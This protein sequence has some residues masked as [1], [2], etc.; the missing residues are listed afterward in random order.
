[1]KDLLRN[2]FEQ[3][4][5]TNGPTRVVI[6]AGVLLAVLVAGVA[7]FQA[8]NPHFVMLY[9]DINDGDVAAVEAAIAKA[10]IR[11]RTSP[12]PGPYNIFVEESEEFAARAIVATESALLRDPGGIDASTGGASSVF[13]S[14]SERNQQTLKKKWGEVEQMLAVYRWIASAKVQSSTPNNSPLSKHKARPTVS[15]VLTLR[16]LTELDREQ[17][18][19]VAQIVRFSFDVPSENVMISDQTGRRLFD[20]S[21]DRG[22]DEMMDWEES[23]DRIRTQRVQ[24]FLDMTYGPGLTRASV[25]ADWNYVR[26]ET[27]SET[28]D[29]KGIAVSEETSDTSTPLN[30]PMAGGPAGVASNLVGGAGQTSVPTPAP[31]EPATTSD[32]RKEFIVGRNTTH[33]TTPNPILERLSVTIFA[34]DSLSAQLVEMESTVKGIVG[35]DALRG[36]LYSGKSAPMYGIERDDDG[37]IVVALPVP[38]EEPMSPTMEMLIEHGVEIVAALAFLFVLLRSL[39]KSQAPLH[40][41]ASATGAGSDEEIDADRLAR[42]HIEQL[43][44]SDPEKVAALLSRWALG[45]SYY[46][47]PGS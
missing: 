30:K 28:V 34:D 15:V 6:G 25:H 45:D 22:L 9:Q 23:F 17:S 26:S 13:M 37:K 1:M 31:E 38:V 8:S 2:L 3:L 42:A 27:V 11:F 39:K 33:T 16:G 29:P 47:R 41:D 18:E 24:E 19:T 35:F 40:S 21:R 4:K 36:D 20:G 5:A 14:A 46:I 32:T 44:K 10:G 43:L 12:P 7:S